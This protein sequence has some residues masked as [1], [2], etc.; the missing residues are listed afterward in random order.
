MRGVEN[1]NWM[2]RASE[3]LSSAPRD[4]A[5]VSLRVPTHSPSL[6]VAA[7]CGVTS[8]TSRSA[9]GPAWSAARPALSNPRPVP[10]RVSDSGASLMVTSSST[11]RT[12]NATRSR[13]HARTSTGAWRSP[14]ISTVPGSMSSLSSSAVA[15]PSVFASSRVRLSWS[16]V[17]WATAAV[18]VGRRS[19]TRLGIQRRIWGWSPR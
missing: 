14:S 16:T 6:S 12:V 7:T 11:A 9:T 10:I 17:H 2:S 19:S 13:T 8:S 3:R 4:R 5:R 1:T 18:S 15:I